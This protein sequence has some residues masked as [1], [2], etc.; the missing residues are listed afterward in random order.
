MKNDGYT[1]PQLVLKCLLQV[2]ARELHNNIVSD[3]KDG[4]LKEAIY[5]NDNILISDSKLHSL[6]PPQ[7][8]K[9]PSRYK[10][11][12]GCECCIYAKIMHSLLISWCDTYF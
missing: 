12:C 10:V 8:K 6:F 5:E 3:T 11:M 7:F 2:S 4:G 9:M 1:E